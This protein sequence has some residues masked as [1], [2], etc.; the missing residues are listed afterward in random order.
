MGLWDKITD[1]LSKVTMNDFTPDSFNE[2]DLQVGDVLVTKTPYLVVVHYATYFKRNIDGKE[3]GYVADFAGHSDPEA[4]ANGSELSV[5]PFYKYRKKKKIINVIRNKNT[6][7]TTNQD[8]EN[9]I[10]KYHKHPYHMW[11]FNCEQF[12]DQICNCRIGFDQRAYCVI[13]FV[14]IVAVIAIVVTL[15]FKSFK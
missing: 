5:I 2:D 14:G 3:V 10:V 6:E 11:H 13:L 4:L 7:A 9:A 12:V 15:L 8:V 1:A